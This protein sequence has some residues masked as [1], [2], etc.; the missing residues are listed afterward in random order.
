MHSVPYKSFDLSCRTTHNDI[1]CRDLRLQTIRT[2]QPASAPSAMSDLNSPEKPRSE[3]SLGGSQPHSWSDVTLI[4]DITQESLSRRLSAQCLGEYIQSSSES[5]AE[6][7]SP[8]EPPEQPIPSHIPAQAVCVVKRFR[9]RSRSRGPALPIAPASDITQLG[10]APGIS[11]KPRLLP[12][13]LVPRPSTG[14]PAPESPAARRPTPPRSVNSI[15]RPRMPWDPLPSARPAHQVSFRPRIP[16]P[17]S[18]G[19]LFTVKDLPSHQ[20]ASAESTHR[21]ATKPP[22]PQARPRGLVSRASQKTTRKEACLSAWHEILHILG[23]A[24]SLHSSLANSKYPEA[25]LRKSLDKFTAGTLERYNAAA[26]QLLDFLGLSNRTIASIDVAFLADFLHACENS[27]EEDREVCKIGPRPILK[28]LSWL[29]RH[30]EVPALQPLM[31]A[32]LIRAFLTQ[33][34]TDRKEAL[35][36]PMAVVVESERYICS[37]H[38]PQ[39]LRLFLGGLLLALHGGLRFGDLQRIRLNSLSLTCNSLRGVCWQTKT[40]KRGQ[41]FAV[42]L[43]GISGRSLDSLWVLPFLQAVQSA[44]IAT[45][46]AMGLSVIPDFILTNL[47]GLARPNSTYSQPMAYSQSLA[48]MRHFLTIPWQDSTKPIPVTPE[49]SRAFTLH[50]LKVCLLAAGA[51][52]RATEEARQHQ[53]HH[54]S[55]SVQLYSRDDTILALDLQKQICLAC[56]Q[57]W[58]P[59]R[60]IARG[61]Q[62]PTLEPP[63]HVDRSQPQSAYQVSSFGEGVSRFV[64][65]AA[66][67]QSEPS[68]EP[69]DSQGSQNDARPKFTAAQIPEDDTEALLVEKFANQAHSSSESDEEHLATT[70]AQLS[71]FS[72]FRNGP[73]GVIHA[74][75]QGDDRAACGASKTSAAF[76]PSCPLPQFFC[77]RK[78]CYRLLDAMP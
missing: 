23:S 39:D 73:W 75:R 31:Q 53:G 40:T 32:S 33:P 47:G 60:P 36:L 38:C 16:Q 6:Q 15:K 68:Q 56:A 8:T 61:G 50:S 66:L 52:V 29:S 41:P 5:E 65:E 10:N 37:P 24:S 25:L 71:T 35:P 43:H 63:F 19:G 62:P 21:T 59:A 11:D 78:A 46:S 44:W 54:K 69:E 18:K 13:S 57:G 42:T 20:P 77:K 17:P 34:T 7:P 45:E 76:S 2:D 9:V 49:E 26:R 64:R 1:P 67:E 4:E 12:L 14:L 51:Q 30:A 27:L 48:A 22:A 72:L 55:P 74:C 3:P 28:A 70:E 58:R